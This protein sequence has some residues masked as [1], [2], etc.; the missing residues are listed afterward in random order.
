MIE[1]SG[2]I[3]L[4]NRSGSRRP[5]NLWIRGIRIRIRNTGP[6]HQS[7]CT[8]SHVCISLSGVCRDGDYLEIL[9]VVSEH[10]HK[11]G[12]AIKNPPKK[13]HPKNPPK[14]PAQKNLKKLI[15]KK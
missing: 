11:A 1:G 10:N 8:V 14:K 3:P 13:T 12:L 4:T 15:Y 7:P 2:S 9:Y 6:R 5:K